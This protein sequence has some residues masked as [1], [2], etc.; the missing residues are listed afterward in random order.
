MATDLRQRWDLDA[1]CKKGLVIIV[2]IDDKKFW[3]SR[4]SKVPVYAGE[5]NELLNAQVIFDRVK[6]TKAFK[7]LDSSF[8]TK[9]VSTSTSQH[10][11]R[12]C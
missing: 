3:V 4:D 6:A 2:S 5:F 1:Q 8:P 11:P 12:N 9:E 10:H 7:S